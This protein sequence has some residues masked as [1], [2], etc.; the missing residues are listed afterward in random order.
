VPSTILSNW[1]VLREYEVRP[2]DLDSDDRPSAASLERLFTRVRGELFD[3]CPGLAR[4]SDS[5]GISPVTVRVRFRR[6]PGPA[7][8][9]RLAVSVVVS[10]IRESS[11]TARA[12]FRSLSGQDWVADSESVHTL[13]AGTTGALPVPPEV[14]D[15]FIDLAR[16]GAH[17][18]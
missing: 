16:N 17:F 2:S 10:E 15:D 9:T 12:R 18:N 4:L 7:P 14:R 5:A 13:K 1:P 3:M 8:T 11:F 6:D